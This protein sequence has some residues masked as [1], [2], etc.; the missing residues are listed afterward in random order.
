MATSTVVCIA[1]GLIVDDT[2]HFLVQ[3]RHAR[4]VLG[5]DAVGAVQYAYMTSG[6]AIITTTFI[7]TAGFIALTF[8]TFS[9]TATTGMLLSIT[10]VTALF[11][12]LF[13]V[14]ALL[15]MLDKK[16]L[17]GEVTHAGG[18]HPHAMPLEGGNLATYR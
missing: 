16:T 11:V 13:F 14:P 5:K 17:V 3:Y 10:I 6:L 7:L 1:I 12:D 9:A 18:H 15:I 8:S 4:Q 2:V